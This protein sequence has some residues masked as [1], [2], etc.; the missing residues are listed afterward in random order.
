M[1]NVTFSNFDLDDWKAN[2]SG[3]E[4]ELADA[5]ESIGIVVAEIDQATLNVASVVEQT[6]SY[7]TGYLN[8]GTYF[9]ITGRNF[10]TAPNLFT[11]RFSGGRDSVYIEG[12]FPYQADRGTVRKVELSDGVFSFTATGNLQ[13][14]FGNAF[15]ASISGTLQ[16]LTVQS[17]DLNVTLQGNLEIRSDDIIGGSITYLDV[18]YEAIDFTASGVIPYSNSLQASLLNS[19]PTDTNPTPDTPTEKASRIR[20][21]NADVGNE[22]FQG[23]P[24]KIDLVKISSNFTNFSIQKVGNTVVVLDNAGVGGEDTLVGIERIQFA[25]KGLAFDTDGATSAG[26][27]YRLYK[28]TF[29]REPDSSGLGYWISE[30]DA[31]AKDAVRMAEDFVWSQEFQDLYNITTTDNY[32]TGTDVSE[33]VTGFYENVLGRTPDQ[34]GLDF[35]TGVIESKERTV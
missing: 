18:D 4:D 26:G 21:L 6:D 33:L 14:S 32:G 23:T 17:P 19:L 13:Y 30:A 2:S 20:E 11:A 22:V 24:D 35:Y 16:T 3:L 28:A 5:I 34:G 29:N 12:N 15:A 7:V 31:E 10:L 9:E 27:I 25:D 8:T 1:S